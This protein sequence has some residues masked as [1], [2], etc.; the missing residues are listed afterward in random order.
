MGAKARYVS[1]LDLVSQVVGLERSPIE[2]GLRVSLLIIG[3]INQS[4]IS[5]GSIDPA[6]SAVE[7]VESRKSLLVLEPTSLTTAT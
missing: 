3:D 5:S 7:G 2:D 4:K 1:R 6:D